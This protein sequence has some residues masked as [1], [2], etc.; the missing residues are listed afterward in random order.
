M[1]DIEDFLVYVYILL[2]RNNKEPFHCETALNYYSLIS[3]TFPSLEGITFSII[4]SKST[5]NAVK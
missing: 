1:N 3:L 5:S 4:S 2:F